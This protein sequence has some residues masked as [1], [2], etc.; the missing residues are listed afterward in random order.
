MNVAAWELTL[1]H[2]VLH[3]EPYFTVELIG[4]GNSVAGSWCAC[5]GVCVSTCTCVPV[6]LTLFSALR[7][8]FPTQTC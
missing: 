6:R 5:V 8:Y 3:Q 1:L 2:I 4:I 7:C